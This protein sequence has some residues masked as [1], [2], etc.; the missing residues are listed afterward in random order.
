LGDWRKYPGGVDTGRVLQWLDDQSL[1]EETVESYQE[2]GNN[3]PT[4]IVTRAITFGDYYS[5]K[6]GL[7][8]E[9]E[10][11]ESV[12]ANLLVKVILDGV[13]QTRIGP[14][15]IPFQ[16]LSEPRLRLPFRLPIVPP[17]LP[18]RL[19]ASPGLLRKAFDLQR[20]GTW[21]ELQFSISS[22]ADKLAIRSIRVTG[23]VDT[24]RLQTIPTTGIPG[25]ADVPGVPPP[26]SSGG[27]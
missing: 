9:F 17:E 20:Y 21:R 15:A 1:D 25:F 23:F 6:T 10:F 12:A 16:T 19:P 14:I 2:F 5:F 27:P 22:A 24:I 11:D 3:I 8:V 4:T 26:A 13:E 7:S 18:L